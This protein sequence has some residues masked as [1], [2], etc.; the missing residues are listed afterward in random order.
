MDQPDSG[1]WDV[2][3]Q[4]DYFGA[5]WVSI[6]LTFWAAVFS[7]VL[8]TVLAIMRVS[9][10]GS[11]RRAAT[12]YVNTVRNL[13]LTLVILACSL[14]LWGQLGVVLASEESSDFISTNSFRL[15]VLGLTLY[16]SCFVCESLRSGINTVPVGQSEAAR[17]IGLGFGQ[18]MGLVILPQA[19]R[20]A[21][22]PLGNTL[23]ALAKNTTVAQAA[24]VV[25][26]SSFMITA[27]DQN[28]NMIFP[29]FVVV[30]I[31]WV[32]VVLPIGLITTSLS[33]RFGVSR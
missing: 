31:G 20:G 1:I 24:G 12:M 7:F 8:G 18:V 2:M 28:G 11:L 30:A 21:I 13:P 32:A 27:I 15:A 25:Q 4:Y 19:I 6:Q 10:V 23:V 29:I 5:F 14:G 17:S 9:P 16:T 22:T 33:R 26:A 3:L